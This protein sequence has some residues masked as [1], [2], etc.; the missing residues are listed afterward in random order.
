MTTNPGIKAHFLRPDIRAIRVGERRRNVLEKGACENI[1]KL[2]RNP[3]KVATRDA[4]KQGGR[5]VL[6]QEHEEHERHEK[7]G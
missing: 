6:Q 7:H 1:H 5:P 4:P 3:D 2:R